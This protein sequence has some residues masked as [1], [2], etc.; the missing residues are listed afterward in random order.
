MSFTEAP[1]G[2]AVWTVSMLKASPSAS[3]SL[4]SSTDNSTFTT[5][6]PAL[7]YT[8]SPP[9]TGALL[10]GITVNTNDRS[11]ALPA[12]SVTVTVMIPLPD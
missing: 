7:R 6:P 11:V 1:S 12:K 9:A 4:A 2:R 8:T 5:R 3:V 10:P